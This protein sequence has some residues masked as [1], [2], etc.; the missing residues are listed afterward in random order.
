MFAWFLLYHPWLPLLLKYISEACVFFA[1][2]S[3]SISLGGRKGP[4]LHNE[5]E[6]ALLAVSICLFSIFVVSHERFLL[7]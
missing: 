3:W 5:N 7:Y 2:L 4:S 1:S 6:N